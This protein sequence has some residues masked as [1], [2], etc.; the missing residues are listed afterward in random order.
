MCIYCASL[1]KTLTMRYLTKT[2]KLIP[3]ARGAFRA[4][5]GKGA[6][7]SESQSISDLAYLSIISQNR[8]LQQPS[9]H[10]HIELWGDSIISGADYQ[11]IGSLARSRLA[12]FSK[13]KVM[14]EILTLLCPNLEPEKMEGVKKRLIAIAKN[15]SIGAGSLL[16][17][18]SQSKSVTIPCSGKM[19]K[20]GVDGL[21][22]QGI[23]LACLMEA[24]FPKEKAEDLSF[25][26]ANST[27]SLFYQNLGY[28]AQ[29]APKS[30]SN[31]FIFSLANDAS[32]GALFGSI[33][34]GGY[35]Q[36]KL[37]SIFESASKNL[38]FGD[39]GKEGLAYSLMAKAAISP[40][41]GDLNAA[42]LIYLL[43]NN[44]GARIMEFKEKCPLLPSH[45][46]D[47]GKNFKDA[48]DGL[49]RVLGATDGAG[50]ASEYLSGKNYSYES[51]A[52]QCF[53]S[54]L[55]S[56]KTSEKDLV[57]T[58]PFVSLLLS[59]HSAP[60]SASS[61][62][63]NAKRNIDSLLGFMFKPELLETRRNFAQLMAESPP[64]DIITNPRDDYLFPSGAAFPPISPF[65]I[66]SYTIFAQDM[67]EPAG[68]GRGFEFRPEKPVFR[69]FVS[70]SVY[71]GGNEMPFTISPHATYLFKAKQPV[72]GDYEEKIGKG[73]GIEGVS[74]A[75][76]E[77]YLASIRR[78][79]DKFPDIYMDMYGKDLIDKR[80][81]PVGR[82]MR[83][84][85]YPNPALRSST[86]TFNIH[87][88][89]DTRNFCLRIY[90]EKG[91]L[92]ESPFENSTFKAGD[93]S[94]PY[95]LPD[96]L[97]SGMLVAIISSNGEK[98]S[99]KLIVK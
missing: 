77:L 38:G 53:L 4:M 96:N 58:I 26:L 3:M 31:S 24:D 23:Y 13:N 42:L 87:L 29:S 66:V 14:D 17:Y 35:S 10:E 15:I 98:A 64:K 20:A 46:L 83:I 48:M 61:A 75:I 91:S 73:S 19:T 65:Q 1:V 2:A 89:D 93:H 57:L 5:G 56:P 40:G 88:K 76:E 99:V 60:G 74:A 80:Y 81:G 94:I 71:L 86:V 78:L 67:A 22:L 21:V 18:D 28:A 59:H 92:I 49:F 41:P 7:T 52:T 82:P 62:V 37:Y 72:Y 27:L 39:S 45:L 8:F 90:S 50:M 51:I 34:S 47:F 70:A 63:I 43:G 55:F 95:A 85:A 11:S 84:E 16:S 12:Y 54:Q 32:G 25:L 68:M 6:E 97:S 79:K 9:R 44:A 33:L 36:R 30:N 69:Y